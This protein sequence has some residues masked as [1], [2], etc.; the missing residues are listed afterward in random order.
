[1]GR[2]HDD[3]PL[4]RWCMEQG[5]AEIEK[6][7]DQVLSNLPGRPLAWALRAAIL[8]LRLARGPG[9]A[10]TRECA[11]LLLKP[12]PT[13][14]RLAADL[15]RSA[16]GGQGDDDPLA[17]LTRA[18]AVVDAVQ[19]I[20]DRL[21]Q[22]GVRDWREAH[23]HGAITATQAA[24]LEEAEAIVS[25]VLQVDDFAPEE[26]APGQEPGPAPAPKGD[27]SS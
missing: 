15:Q 25:R 22:S 18:F 3:L 9:D 14:A 1:E 8:P 16:G 19:P 27:Q 26:L 17:L 6:R 2:K 21:R 4:V 11:E 23:R 5:Y 24:Q 10:L 13:H 20:R 7:M 12:S